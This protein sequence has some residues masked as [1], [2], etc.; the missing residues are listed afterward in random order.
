MMIRGSKVRVY[1]HG[2]PEQAAIGTVELISSN[3][4]SIAVSFTDKPPFVR[5]MAVLGPNGIYL[6]ASRRMLN[7]VPWGPWEELTGQGHYEIEEDD[8]QV[9]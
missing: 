2:Y 1:P 3:Q 5:L 9:L 6:L 8:A 4:L 7:G